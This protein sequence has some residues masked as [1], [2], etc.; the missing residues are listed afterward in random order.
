M[1]GRQDN[2]KNASRSRKEASRNTTEI[3]QEV[4]LE[5]LIIYLESLQMIRPYEDPSVQRH[6]QNIRQILQSTY[7]ESLA[8]VEAS[9][10]STSNKTATI[11]PEQAQ[12]IFQTIQEERFL[13]EYHRYQEALKGTVSV[14]NGDT[15][16][17]LQPNFFDVVAVRNAL[18][19]HDRDGK[20]F[21]G[22]K[23]KNPTVAHWDNLCNYY[24]GLQKPIETNAAFAA[25]NMPSS[26]PEN[27]HLSEALH[28]LHIAITFTIPSLQKHSSFLLSRKQSLE[29]R[30]Y[31]M[32]RKQGELMH[33]YSKE[34]SPLGISFALL[35]SS[36]YETNDSFEIHIYESAKK[37]LSTILEETLPKMLQ[38]ELLTLT[39]DYHTQMMQLVQQT[40]GVEISAPLSTI[41]S[42]LIQSFQKKE[43]HH[44]ILDINSDSILLETKEFVQELSC[45][46][47]ELAGFLGQRLAELEKGGNCPSPCKTELAKE[48]LQKTLDTL[49]NINNLLTRGETPL[50][51]QFFE[52]P[53]CRKRLVNRLRL[54][55][56]EIRS[57]Q[58]SIQT[59]E[60]DL[61]VLRNQQNDMSKLLQ[62]HLKRSEM[63]RKNV[64]LE[65][66]KVMKTG[67]SLKIL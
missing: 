10:L 66:A 55:L 36:T 22:Q 4:Q 40:T 31:E 5:N 57:Q 6:L 13:G 30:R 67:K 47:S 52:Y 61:E 50:L 60:N 2:D 32:K 11:S 15:Y 41:K 29:R 8:A 42:A 25:D 37:E 33:S 27:S 1:F 59:I 28:I 20:T 58:S 9:M 23:F 34:F 18:I 51:V 12:V 7:S 17:L 16:M 62:Q 54:A 46:V 44:A 64:E 38:T 26:L 39:I 24:M 14:T 3:Y 53:N 63:L 49:K 56:D 35:L 43:D 48:D 45:D 19:R 65:A 21:I